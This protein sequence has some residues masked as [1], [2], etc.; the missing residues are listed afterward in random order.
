[1]C[2]KAYTVMM[3]CPLTKAYYENL[4]KIGDLSLLLE[5]EQ[6]YCKK[7]EI[8]TELEV[9]KKINKRI[10]WGIDKFRK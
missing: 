4:D 10:Y 2:A 8:K 5:Q 3:K 9:I 6:D 1:L 7:R